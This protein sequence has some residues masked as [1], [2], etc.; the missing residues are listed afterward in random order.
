MQKQATVVSVNET[1][2]S[3]C[4]AHHSMVDPTQKQYGVIGVPNTEGVAPAAKATAT[5]DPKS[6]VLPDEGAPAN[7]CSVSRTSTALT[8]SVNT[9][10]SKYTRPATID[11]I[12]GPDSVITVT[13]HSIS[14]EVHSMVPSGKRDGTMSTTSSDPGHHRLVHCGLGQMAERG[15]SAN[16]ERPK[17]V[18]QPRQLVPPSPSGNY[19]DRDGYGDSSEYNP[20]HI[21]DTDARAK[22]NEFQHVE[23]WP[24]DKNHGDPHR[25]ETQDANV[26]HERSDQTESHDAKYDRTQY[27]DALT[28]AI[29][30][31]KT[32][33]NIVGDVS[34][35]ASKTNLRQPLDLEDEDSHEEQVVNNDNSG[36]GE[37]SD[38]EAQSRTKRQ[39]KKWQ[40][41]FQC[42]QKH[43]GSNRDTNPNARTI[44]VLEQMGHYYD[45]IDDHWRTIAYRKA[46][47]TLRKQTTKITT[48][49]EALR[50]PFIGD[51]LA[52]K[53]QEIVWT[54][55]LRRLDNALLDPS[56]QVLQLFMQI[57]GVGLSQASRW[58]NMG[59]KTFDDLR[60][61]VK[62]TENQKIGL[63]HFDDFRARIPRQGVQQHG[64]IVSQALQE[65]DPAFE[66]TIGGSYR[67]GASDSGD[68]D[69]IITK[70]DANL[71]FIRT[72]VLDQLV[73]MLFEKGFLKAALA[74]TH[75]ETGTKWHGVSALPGSN[76]WR[77]ID[78]LLVP[79]DQLGAA[80]IYFTGNDIFN[81]SIR[82]LASKK[83]MRLN[84]RGLYRNVMRGKG[85]EKITEGE[86]VEG[87]SEKK[88]FEILGVPWRSPEH[89]IC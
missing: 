5:K 1:Y 52:E 6:L 50:L 14:D 71:D 28:A 63:A 16:F 33:G 83:G 11:T 75:P 80:L 68:I 22:R 86:L 64:S 43:D 73:P 3:D 7:P 85:R 35:V 37:T 61:N 30:E 70:P 84:Q 15:R 26:S 66:A 18:V 87:K 8:T 39:R 47:A 72:V 27:D 2:L 24:A 19:P 76:V 88:I 40:E 49:D 54:N 4:I 38:E 67:R 23:L 9:E 17:G 32:L 36:G 62:L 57:Y 59:F 82:L 25:A 41:N 81:R 31:A 48:K 89:R 51:R 42:M 74:K 60:N 45:R 21:V 69:L 10:N 58:V 53:I 77:R 13:T 46:V 78:F 79:W 44:E 29:A 12:R 65:I 20:Q 55:N 56:D 34:V